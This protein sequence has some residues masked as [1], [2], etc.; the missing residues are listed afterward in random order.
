MGDTSRA[1]SLYREAIASAAAVGAR[2][3]EL[4]STL[5]FARLGGAS[6][7]ARLQSIFDGFTDGFEH[8]DLR[9]A[10][11]FLAARGSD[12]HRKGA[13]AAPARLL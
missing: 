7:R 10:A 1:A 2:L 13:D 12:G 4:R 5:A 9:D 6:E 8:T 3:L 11:A